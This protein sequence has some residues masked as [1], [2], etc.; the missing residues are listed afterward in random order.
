MLR[1]TLDFYV[2][3]ELADA[4]FTR[5]VTTIQARDFAGAVLLYT[6]I[7]GAKAIADADMARDRGTWS[8]VTGPIPPPASF[9]PSLLENYD[10]WPAPTL[11][12]P[13]PASLTDEEAQGANNIDSMQTD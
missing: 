10:A 6:G 9:P 1:C 13:A 7:L 8:Q 11:N 3:A 12:A 4:F 5:L 2:P